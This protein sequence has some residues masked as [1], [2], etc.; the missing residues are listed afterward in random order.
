MGDK[1]QAPET[2]P[3]A[4]V[5]GINGGRVRTKAGESDAE[6]EKHQ[7]EK[8]TMVMPISLV[9]AAA[10]PNTTASPTCRQWAARLPTLQRA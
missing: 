2:A 1:R 8:L 6:G 7:E 9:K 3:G 5:G 4:G 10:Q